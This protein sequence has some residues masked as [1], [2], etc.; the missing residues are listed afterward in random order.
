MDWISVEDSP[1][2]HLS[3]PV[4]PSSPSNTQRIR[5]ES[6]P[7]FSESPS[8]HGNQSKSERPI[9]S[10]TSKFQLHRSNTAKKPAI[11]AVL[12]KESS[13]YGDDLWLAGE[14]LDG[15]DITEPVNQ[16]GEL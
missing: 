3:P 16:T 5:R 11:P 12:L 13:D 2:T 4:Y 10:I 14:D 6:S 9:H 1:D 7:Y 15:V 8:Y